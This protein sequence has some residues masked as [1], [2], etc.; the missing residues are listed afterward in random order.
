MLMKFQFGFLSIVA[1]FVFGWAQDLTAQTYPSRPIRLIV[2]YPPGGG[3]DILARLFAHKLSES[4]GQQVVVD[5]RPGAGG[6]IGANV[7]AKSPADG[8]TVFMA[9]APHSIAP[10]L[11]KKLPYVLLRDFVPISLV[12]RQQLCLVVHPSLPPKSVKE[13]VSFLRARPDQVSYA[14]AGNGGSNHLAAELFKTMAGVKMIHVPYKGTGPSIADVL[15]GQVPVTFGNLLPIMPHIKSGR[16]R[17]LAVTALQRSPALP[18]VPTLAE[19]GYPNY[20]AVNWYGILAPAGTSS[21]ITQRLNMEIV[22]IL[23]MQDVKDRYESLG[24]EPVSSTSEQARSF[25]KKEIEKW[26]K[27]V[28]IS[29]ARVD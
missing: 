8:Y 24:T 16:V 22:K 1:T 2:G 25:I 23:N 5:N 3:S 21:E 6:N 11:Y 20:E 13:F 19:S 12:A 7:A 9:S 27:V 4:L 15:S 18:N 17:A 26:A 14:S 10:S 28:E 29:G